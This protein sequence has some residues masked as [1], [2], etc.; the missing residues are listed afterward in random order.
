MRSPLSLIGKSLLMLLLLAAGAVGIQL[1]SFSSSSGDG[2]LEHQRLFNESYKVFSLTLPD[3]MDIFGEKVPLHLL[4]V[5]ERLDRELLVNT[6]WQ[7]NSLLI[8]KRANR[9]FPVI[10]P[11]L[12]REG[13]PDDL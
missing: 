6:Y 5:R 13:V 2:D 4:D 11:I 12:K 8:H 1:L 7:S 9:W 10:E 3:K